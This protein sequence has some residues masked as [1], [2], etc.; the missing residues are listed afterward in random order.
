MFGIEKD[1]LMHTNEE[2]IA[3]V[4]SGAIK[5]ANNSMDALTDSHSET[6]FDLP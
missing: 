2:L 3:R 4:M 1:V 5:R 6:I